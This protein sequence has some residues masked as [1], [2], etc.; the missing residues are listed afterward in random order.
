VVA[1]HPCQGEPVERPLAAVVA[2]HPCQG[3]PVERPLAAVVASHPCQGEPVERPLAAV[4][5]SQE[6]LAAFRAVVVASLV[7][8]H[9]CNFLL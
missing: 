4:V 9:S 8:H 5:A 3:E 2:S 7:L 6:G 1:S